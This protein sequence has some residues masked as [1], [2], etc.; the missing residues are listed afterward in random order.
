[1]QSD[2]D[3]ETAIAITIAIKNQSGKIGTIFIV[4]SDPDFPVKIDPRF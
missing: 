2:P 4:E 3:F 1:V